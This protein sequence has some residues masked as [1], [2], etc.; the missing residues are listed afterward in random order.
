MTSVNDLGRYFTRL[1]RQEDM[2]PA[3]RAFMLDCL[4]GQTDTECFPAAFPDAR[5]AHKT[6]ELDGLYDDGGIILRHDEPLI[7]CIMDDD[8]FSRYL[9]I[10]TMKE[11]AKTIGA[12][13]VQ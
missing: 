8:I 1:W 9:T 13:Y 12:V 6:G 10:R 11:V 3:S 7:L 2:S 4:F 5:I